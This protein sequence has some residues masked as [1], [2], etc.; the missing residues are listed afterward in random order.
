MEINALLADQAAKQNI[1]DQ[2]VPKGTR[3]CRI[4]ISESF[5]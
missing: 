5:E 3:P 1:Y 2:A 4:R